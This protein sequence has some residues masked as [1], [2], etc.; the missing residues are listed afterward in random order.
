[1]KVVS[2]AFLCL[3]VLLASSCSPIEM[4]MTEFAK[5]KPFKGKV[6]KVE[7]IPSKNPPRSV[8]G[9]DFRVTVTKPDGST[10]IITR[11]ETYLETAVRL[12]KLVEKSECD[13]PDEIIQYED[14][15]GQETR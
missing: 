11:I 13:L 9:P 14:K 3:L 6:T 1:L 2:T 15:H 10:I 8:S 7:Q 4:T 12:Q 5:L